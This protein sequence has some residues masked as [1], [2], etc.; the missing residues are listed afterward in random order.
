MTTDGAISLRPARMS[1]VKAMAAIELAA[2]SDPWPASS[3]AD[4]LPMTHARMVVAVDADEKLVGYCVLIS[5]ADEGEIA[6]IAVRPTERRRG[7]GALLLDDALAVAA[8]TG[9]MQLF[10]EVRTSNTAARALYASR[11]FLP[12]GRR[13]AYYNDPVE[14]ALVLRRTVPKQALE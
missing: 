14:D 12:V 1:D 3:F 4:M 7:I 9:V 6:N 8:R 11:G 10:L 5:A 13:I 2:F